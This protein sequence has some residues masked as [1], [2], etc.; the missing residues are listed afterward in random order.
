LTSDDD[1]GEEDGL[2]KTS[3]TLGGLLSFSRTCVAKHGLFTIRLEKL[4]GI[5]L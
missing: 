1:T 2:G 5:Y 4:V 3:E